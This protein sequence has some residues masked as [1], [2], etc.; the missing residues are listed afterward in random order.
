MTAKPIKY[1]RLD[2]CPNLDA[3]TEFAHAWSRMAANGYRYGRDALENVH[4][5]WLMAR[6][7]P[8]IVLTVRQLRAALEFA[9]AGDEEDTEITI[10]WSAN[11]QEDDGP[12]CLRPGLFMYIT[13]YPEEGYVPL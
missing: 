9:G 11:V 5:G 1:N 6:L 7:E 8:K 10:V 4:V 3:D 13:D 12:A 2:G